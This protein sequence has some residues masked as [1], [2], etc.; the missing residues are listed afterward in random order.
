MTIGLANSARRL[1][2]LAAAVLALALCAGLALAATD[3]GAKKKKGA[4]VFQA[5][6]AVN[7]AIPDRP[8]NN[9]TSIAVRSTITVGKKFKGK[10]VGDLNVTGITTLGNVAGAANDLNFKLTAPNGRSVNLFGGIGGANGINIGPLTLD[11]D[12]RVSLCFSANPPCSDPFATLNPPY[13]GTA[14][15]KFTASGGTGPLSAFDGVGMRGT[16]TMSVY[17][18][19]AAPPITTSIWSSWGLKITP[20]APAT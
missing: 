2:L 1:R 13:V 19:A 20:Q 12:T 8:A 15:L 14:N 6:Q 4:K 3:A 11:D 7:Q 9:L 10:L 18:F 5:T 17:D 16:W